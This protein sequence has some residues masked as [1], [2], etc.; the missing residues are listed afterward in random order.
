[1]SRTAVFCFPGDIDTPTG[2][3]R[4]D[5]RILRGCTGF[6]A[7]SLPGAY[8]FPDAGAVAAATRAI[9]AIPD[10]TVVV[11]D[12]L[13]LGVLPQVFEHEQDRLALIALVHHPLHL[14]TGL[15]DAAQASLA[16]AERRA[17]ATVRRVVVTSERTVADVVAL[18]VAR[19]R[20][21]VI[22]PGTEHHAS[23]AQSR[24]PGTGAVIATPGAAGAPLRL[25]CV[26]SVVPRKGYLDLLDALARVDPG[27]GGWRLT[28]VGSLSRDPPHARAVLDKAAAFGPAVEFVGERDEAALAACY[29]RA[30][31]FV[32]ASRHEGFGMVLTE[33]ISHGLPIVATRAGAIP[34]TVG[35]GSP[36]CPALLAAAGDVAGLAAAIDRLLRDPSERAR[37]AQA[38]LAR[39][40][41]LPG[42]SSACERFDA[43]VAEF[44]PPAADALGFDADWLAM[45][46]PFDRDA[47]TRASL[48][49]LIADATAATSHASR[50][51]IGVDLGGGTGS[52]LRCLIPAIGGA[53]RWTLADRDP[54]LLDAAFAAFAPGRDAHGAQ[55]ER[56]AGG[57]RVSARA[58]DASI[59]LR[60]I[61][62]RTARLRDELRDASIVAASALLDLV[63]L[64]WF[65]SLVDA[66]STGRAMLVFSLNY[67]G[68]IEWTP[69]HP[70]DE[71]I[72][73]AMNADQRTD[74][75]FGPALGPD[76][77]TQVPACLE[78]AGYT[79]TI[80]RSDWLI[81]AGDAR[82]QA[83]LIEDLA[84]IAGRQ[85]GVDASRRASIEQWRLARRAR[86]ADAGA[87]L[88]VGHVE[89]VARR[90]A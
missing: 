62:L 47:R 52:F 11:V 84:A 89:I 50:P 21:V 74:K 70:G 18:G 38:A 22:E 8:P 60:A 71:A 14:E 69:T 57:L 15:D 12:G 6:E 68:R 17:L 45:R 46:E 64:R 54:A 53:Q 3:Y 7:L 19:E 56:V 1:M 9:A 31:A 39:R 51:I 83:R 48:G 26:A 90:S 40:A 55:L 65:E 78:A 72:T 42:W 67:D 77:A 16:A 49:R 29:E 59:A 66:A 33:A 10:R 86:L 82:M 61:D 35:D 37:L 5:R 81:G 34:D 27:A 87:T 13:A 24:E 80:A 58:W 41:A 28:C 85:P 63:S 44:G 75:G 76:C 32:L 23:H 79:C 30:D 2:G 88:R 73:R 43:L 25:L 20:I 4:Y 36:D